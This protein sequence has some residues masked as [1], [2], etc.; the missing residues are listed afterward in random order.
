MGRLEGKV[1]IITG[2]AGG[3]GLAGAQLFAEEGAKVMMTD[4]QGELLEAEAAKI[5]GDVVAMRQ[6]VASADDWAAVVRRTV[7]EF[8]KIDIL[9][10]NAGVVADTGV[11]ETEEKD[12]DWVL[13]VNLKGVWLGMK[14]V[15]P[16]LQSNGGGAIVNCSSI[17]GLVGGQYSAGAPYSASKGGVRSLTKHAAQWYAKDRIRI[18]SVHPGWVYTPMVESVAGPERAALESEEVTGT[19]LPPHIGDPMDIAYAYL[20]LA[21]EES[22]FITAEELVVDGGAVT[23]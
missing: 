3:M 19:P 1:A 16:H 7:D 9:V 10:N 5:D 12:W 14:A 20:Y 23:R 15:I 6:D 2:A 4:V 11:L 17:A 21:S 22:K 18:N 13:G 8:G